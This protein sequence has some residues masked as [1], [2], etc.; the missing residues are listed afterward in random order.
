[1]IK[2]Y[3]FELSGNCYKVRLLLDA[4]KNEVRR[5]AVAVGDELVRLVL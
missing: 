3:D 4:Q 1:M 2:L 5:L